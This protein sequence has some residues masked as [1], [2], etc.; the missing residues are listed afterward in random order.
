MLKGGHTMK[1]KG[2]RLGPIGTATRLVVAAVLL[3][4]AFFDGTSWGLEWYDA[5]VGLAVLPAAGLALGLAARRYASGPVHFMG[6]A[7]TT[8]NCLL[9][10]GLGVNPYTAGGAA[11]FYGATLIVATSRGEPGCEA[12]VVSNAILGRDDQIGCP[13]FSPDRRGRGAARG[14]ESRPQPAAGSC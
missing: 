12:T 5:T 1:L 6:S 14:A 7:G 9:L 4:L 11:L 2:R 13:L 8:A 10:V 3:Y